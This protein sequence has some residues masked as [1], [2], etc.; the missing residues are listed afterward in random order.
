MKA[1]AIDTRLLFLLSENEWK[2]IKHRLI[3]AHILPAGALA[4]RKQSKLGR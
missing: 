1:H 4:L 3:N 2:P